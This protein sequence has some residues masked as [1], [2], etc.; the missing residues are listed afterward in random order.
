MSFGLLLGTSFA[1]E[2]L[3]IF[4]SLGMLVGEAIGSCIKKNK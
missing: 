1:S 3:G 2:H 4:L